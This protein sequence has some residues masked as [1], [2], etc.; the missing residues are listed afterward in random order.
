MKSKK[1]LIL[2][3]VTCLPHAALSRA[4]QTSQK[5]LCPGFCWQACEAFENEEFSSSF[6]LNKILL[7][8]LSFKK[9]SFVFSYTVEFVR[10]D[11]LA[12]SFR[13]FRSGTDPP[14]R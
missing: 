1:Q 8:F 5:S 10:K 13:C 12:K 7:T 3:L 11:F 4:R 2:L 6:D 9:A 14:Q